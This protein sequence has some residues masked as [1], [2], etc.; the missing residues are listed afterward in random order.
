MRDRPARAETERAGL[1]LVPWAPLR[2]DWWML[3]PG[4]P[5]GTYGGAAGL[6][7]RDAHRPEGSAE[8]PGWRRWGRCVCGT[9]ALW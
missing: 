3:Q 9:P 6:W 5:T 2:E 1:A 4:G 8:K 7:A